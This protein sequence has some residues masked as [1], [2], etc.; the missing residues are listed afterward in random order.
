VCAEKQM[1]V[2]TQI[3][4]KQLNALFPTYNFTELHPTKSGIIDTTYIV[5]TASN[6]YILKRYERDIPTRIERDIKLLSELKSIG[7]NV[8]ICL[9]ESDGWYLYEKLIGAQ[10]K[11][12]NAKH[13]Q[14]MGRFLAKLHTYSSKTKCQTNARV[15]YE[16][17]SALAYAK[18]NFYAYYKKCEF[19][20]KFTV[21]H[22]AFI[23]GDIFKDNTVFNGNQVGVFDFIDG[24]CGTFAFDVAVTLVGFDTK[25][26]NDYFINI[27][28]RA[29]NQH[30]PKK[31]TKQRVIYKM[32]IASHYY[33]IK[34][35]YKYKNTFRAKELIRWI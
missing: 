21:N 2:V 11:N 7:L 25:I 8:P 6:S 16:V 30:A 9:E 22:D 33:A 12:I 32:K 26:D 3:S 28:L 20:K 29:Y 18:T 13:I 10:P 14:V 1:G 19:L 5:D 4:L 15:E 23:H 27:F 24:A 17:T 35:V 34:R 31:L